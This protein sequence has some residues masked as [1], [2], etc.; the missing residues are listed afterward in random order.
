VKRTI[1]LLKAAFAMAILYLVSMAKETFNTNKNFY[2]P[3]SIW[4]HN[5]K[6]N[7]TGKIWRL[8]TRFFL[9]NTLTSD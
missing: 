4:E 5:T 7:P 1:A 6:T 3:E 9:I 8:W 2:Q